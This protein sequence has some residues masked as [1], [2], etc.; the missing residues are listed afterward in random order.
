[1]LKPTGLAA[2][3]IPD[4]VLFDGGAGETVRKKLL[5]TTDVHTILRLPTNIFYANGVKAN[6]VFFATN[7]PAKTHGQRKS[8][9]MITAPT[10]TTHLK[11]I[12]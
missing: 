7:L 11:K 8:G 6:V 3:V 1:M 12:L 5:E 2:V 10:Y 4:N 9:F